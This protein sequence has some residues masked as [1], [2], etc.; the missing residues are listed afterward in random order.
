MLIYT[1]L[2]PVILPLLAAVMVLY[3]SRGTSLNFLLELTL[4]VAP[5]FL[6]NI[7][8]YLK[9]G[10]QSITNVL[11]VYLVVLAI[12]VYIGIRFFSPNLQ[13]SLKMALLVFLIIVPVLLRFYFPSLSE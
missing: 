4:I 3:R 9:V 2:I 12:F 13:P 8:V 7:L 11:E 10:S 1:L 6:W 5:I